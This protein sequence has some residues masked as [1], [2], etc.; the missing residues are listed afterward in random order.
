[1][2]PAVPPT[3]LMRPALT[4][5]GDTFTSGAAYC[6]V[7]KMLVEV[8]STRS[9]GADAAVVSRS[10]LCTPKCQRFSAGPVIEPRAAVPKRPTGGAAYAPGSNQRAAVGSLSSGSA[11]WSGRSVTVGRVAVLVNRV[12]VGSGTEIVG[13]RYPPLCT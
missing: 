13:V 5:A 11:I 4:L 7:L 3:A 2:K 12:P 1:M 9:V 8:S 6:G 10:F